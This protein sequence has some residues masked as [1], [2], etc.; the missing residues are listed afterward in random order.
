MFSLVAA[1]AYA[2]IRIVFLLMKDGSVDFIVFS[3]NFHSWRYSWML[4]EI[5]ATFSIVYFFFFF[6]FNRNVREVENEKQAK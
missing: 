4:L 2:R 6:Y 3:R 1:K 5:G